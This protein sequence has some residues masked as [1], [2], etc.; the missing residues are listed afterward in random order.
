MRN[1]SQRR[2]KMAARMGGL[3]G[4]RRGRNPGGAR[5]REMK[6]ASRSMLSDWEPEDSDAAL[7]EERKQ[8]KQRGSV[9][10]AVIGVEEPA[11]DV[12]WAEIH[13]EFVCAIPIYRRGWESASRRGI[14]IGGE[15]AI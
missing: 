13:R 14:G 2:R 10:G 11:E 1:H 7:T 12:G 5:K 8:R 3:W 15:G 6:P 9:A 4:A